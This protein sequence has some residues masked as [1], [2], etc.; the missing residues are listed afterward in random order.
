M[1]ISCRNCTFAWFLSCWLS[2]GCSRSLF[3]PLFLCAS[4]SPSA[5]TSALH[6]PSS[7]IWT[8]CVGSFASTLYHH[9]RRTPSNCQ[10]L[11]AY[12]HLPPNFSL[13]FMKPAAS[14]SHLPST[15]QA[16]KTRQIEVPGLYKTTPFLSVWP[17]FPFSTCHLQCCLTFPSKCHCPSWRNDT[18]WQIW[19]SHCE[20]RWCIFR[21]GCSLD[22]LSRQDHLGI[23][24]WA[25]SLW[26]P[27]LFAWSLGRPPWSSDMIL[28]W[29]F[30]DCLNDCC[31]DS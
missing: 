12:S 20:S 10:N 5:L 14:R 29:S 18:Y 19:K 30:D 25:W 11:Q 24:S 13:I 27:H 31:G 23:S 21:P 4:S 1:W 8:S 7:W 6:P 28:G 9:F 15:P 22:G 16:Q 26:S 17:S 2:L 3:A